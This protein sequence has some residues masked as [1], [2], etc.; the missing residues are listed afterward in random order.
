VSHRPHAVTVAALAALLLAAP[1]AA[2][3]HAATTKSKVTLA[4]A[5]QSAIVAAHTAVVTV[6]APGAS[7][8]TL[9]LLSN[10]HA[11]TSSRHLTFRRAQRVRLALA[12]TTAG[13][14]RL[15]ACNTQKLDLRATVRRG[16]T[17]STVRDRRT[18]ALDPSA[19]RPSAPATPLPAPPAA[20]APPAPVTPPVHG[21][22]AL[23]PKTPEI[24]L[25]TADH[26][27]ILV[28]GRCIGTWPSDYFTK[29]D[30]TSETGL[31]VNL[32]PA[33]M[34]QNVDGTPIDPTDIDQSDGFSPGQEIL[35]HVAGMDTMAAGEQTGIV[36]VTDLARTYDNDQAVVLIDAAT[37]KRQLIWAE[38]DA[39]A[40]T[41]D[42]RDLMIH[43]AKNLIEGHRYIV[44]LRH[45]RT[46]DDQPI[47]AN[48]AFRIYRDNLPSDQADIE[49]RRPHFESLF[50]TLSKAGIA[51]DDLYL[52]WDFTV[53][54]TQNITGRM[55]SIRNDAFAQLGD[56]DLGDLDVDG[57]SPTFTAN[58]V[59]LTPQ[60]DAHIAR[61][62]TG[63]VTVPCYLAPDCGPGGTFDLDADGNPVQHGTTLAPYTCN[64]PRVVMDDPDALARP[65]MYGHGLFGAYTQTDGGKRGELAEA[66]NLMMC[67]TDFKGMASD[68]QVNAITHILPDMSHFNEMADRL[69]QG[70][71][72]FLYLGRAMIH[73]DGFAGNV[74]FQRADHSALLDTRR[75]YYTGVSE[76]GILGG[77]LTAVAPDFTRAAL[78]VPGMN[79]SVLLPRSTD[80]APFG[81]TLNAAYT[82]ESDRPLVLSMVQMLW[83]RGEPDGYANH[84]TD[85][86]LPDTPAHRVILEAGIGDHQVSNVTTET[87]ARTI[88]A[89]IR[90]PTFDP[91]R[92][93]D[94]TPSYGI[95]AIDHYPFTQNAM[96]MW[97]IG[98]LH[99]NDTLGTPPAPTTNTPPSD[100]VGEDP[101]EFSGQEAEAN[102]QIAAFLNTGGA[103]TDTCD[104]LKPCY[105]AG[106]TGPPN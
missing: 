18:L 19:C 73:P 69:Q 22:G 44:A 104:P 68:D 87:E 29:A 34:P 28:P 75:L 30:P 106:W 65:T 93:L 84:M 32:K 13:T 2:S 17:T 101:H 43:P 51:R 86:P 62:I 9:S 78:V 72:N 58:A 25:S 57:V 105:A 55:L 80:Y 41:D 1:G 6:S 74:N 11:V 67:G 4:T 64:I 20:P 85:D 39:T 5:R 66:G 45:L 81:A 76:G 47:P 38:L 40:T 98:P 15:K 79:Y 83:D 54:S 26:C 33:A 95:P 46:A 97:D 99:A 48:G 96:V 14:K 42:Q 103:F 77:A 60:Q 59:D 50:S 24:D 61:R 52:T 53:A 100:D 70:L 91:G 36:P 63:N 7:K 23:P 12:L 8:V 71:L 35:V 3:A 102:T 89:S 88:G 49:A 56:H 21:T 37:G 31:R 90:T 94:V 92:S 82:T 16:K 27:E 10:G